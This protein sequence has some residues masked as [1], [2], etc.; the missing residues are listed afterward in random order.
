MSE[1][2][3]PEAGPLSFDQAVASLVPQQPEPEANNDAQEAPAEAADEPTE[4]Q[5]DDQAPEEAS[6]EPE[7]QAE[8]AEAD[9]EEPAVEPL[10]PPKYW[11][12]DAKARFA[13]LDPDL[14]AVVLE[15]E[16][17]R[18]AAAAKAKADA[19]AEVQAAQ[20]KL[21]G[22]QTLAEQLGGFLPE[23][24]ETFKSRWGDPDWEA[25]IRQYGAEEAAVLRVR[26][27]K[28]QSQLQQLTQ[29]TQ[30]AR[31][32]AHQA[33]VLE[34]FQALTT[35]DPELAPDLKDPRQGAEKRQAVTKYLI[36]AGVDPE[37]IAQIS[38]VEMTLARK[39]MLWDDAQAK[40]KAPPKPKNPAPKSAPVRPAAAQAQS[41]SQRTAASAQGRFNAKPSIDNA[42]ALLLARK[43]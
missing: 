3:T 26:Y 28:E 42:V 25:T 35:L 10:E 16:G 6:A 37:G 15:Q 39:A 20:A 29:A 27:E 17:P 34:Q 41:P 32:E 14:Q 43:A 11:S 33:Y 24:M 36:D 31:Q 22:V 30:A 5:G 38:A 8:G 21:K 7:E 23:A 12:K 9:A 4:P 1:A 13:E 2:A 18:E 40:L 19:A